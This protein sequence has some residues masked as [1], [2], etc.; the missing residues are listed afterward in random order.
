MLVRE[1]YPDY[2]KN[3]VCT[4]DACEATCCAG[5]QIVVDQESI[6]RYQSVKGA[7]GSR[8]NASIDLEEECFD[9]DGE[10]RC[11][12]LNRDNL[13]DIYTELGEDYLCYTCENYPRH[14][15]EFDGLNE[16]TLSISCPEV[17]KQLLGNTSKVGFVEEEIEV[18]DELYEEIEDF[19]AFFFELLDDSR[20]LLVEI[21]QDRNFP[22]D[23]RIA[24][25]NQIMIEV[26]EEVEEDIFGIGNV[27]E[28]YQAYKSD[29]DAW[30]VP[31]LDVTY[32]KK[33]L[34]NLYELETLN[35]KWRPFLDE[36]V[37]EIDSLTDLSYRI[38]HQQFEESVPLEIVKEQ[39]MIYFLFSYFNGAVYD[40]Y[41][42]SKGQIAIASTYIIEELWFALWLKNGGIITPEEQYQVMYRY[43]R[44]LEHSDE[45]LLTMES[46]ARET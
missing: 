42:Y 18:P 38:K 7:F 24:L 17:A 23:K 43:A 39:M 9:Q 40:G 27:L 41:V 1:R 10:K 6:E 15:E 13:C 28:E 35:E 30:E 19:D 34:A 46:L 8:L 4:A 26:D 32:R 33:Q 12:F 22:I 31:S 16:T 21:L 29:I 3:F 14:I 11:A 44:E 20:A 45:N 5:W 37:Q 25:V 36:M 2:F